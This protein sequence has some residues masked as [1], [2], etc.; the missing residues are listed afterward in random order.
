MIYDISYEYYLVAQLLPATHPIPAHV[1]VQGQAPPTVP[2]VPAEQRVVHDGAAVA[3][4]PFALPH[5]HSIGIVAGRA[6]QLWLRPESVHCRNQNPT[7]F[8]V[9][10]RCTVPAVPAEQ[11]VGH[12]GLVDVLLV[13]LP[14]VGGLDTFDEQN[15]DDPL[16]SLQYQVRDV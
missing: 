8:V 10:T 12:D 1:Q 2:A 16:E 15:C 3:V 6:L 11:R 9:A 14:H 7:E 4:V 5:T 13:A